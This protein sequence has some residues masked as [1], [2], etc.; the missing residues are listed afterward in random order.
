MTETAPARSVLIV[1]DDRYLRRACEVTLRNRG[2]A[3]RTAVDGQAALEAI[4]AEPPA[5]V[6]L[7]LLMPRM[8]GVELLRQLREEEATRGLPVLVLSNSSREQDLAELERL[9]ILGYLV[10]ANLSLEELGHRVS[11]ILEA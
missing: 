3:V 1:E 11:R 8:T 4:R 10:K 6:L 2:F 9:G 5:L 7:D